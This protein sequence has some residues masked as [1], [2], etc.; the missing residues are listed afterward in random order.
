MSETLLSPGILTR[1]ND[2]S[3]VQPAPIEA[4]AAFIGP[5]VK[6]PVL[7]PT[8]V[9]SYNEYVRKFGDVVE[10]QG[11]IV[12]YFTSIGVRQY[13]SQGGT[14]AL[15][16]RVV[17]GSFTSAKASGS[18]IPFTLE[19]LGKGAIYN[20]SGSEGT[21]GSLANGTT[22]N[23]R[24]EVTAV[25]NNT[26][27]FTI[28]LR[29]GDDTIKNK[30]ILESFT[31][32]LDPTSDIFIEK[33]IGTQTRIE[34]TDTGTGDVYFETVGE[35]INR[36][37]FIRVSEIDPITNYTPADSGSLPLA[38]SG[39]FEEALGTISTTAGFFTAASGSTPQGIPAASY[40]KA[41]SLLESKD[42]YQFNIVAAPGINYESNTAAVAGLISLAE[43]RQDCVAVV[44]TVGYGRLVQDVKQSA[45]TID[46]SYAATYWPW[47]QMRSVTGKNVWV[48]ASTVI[49]SIFVLT[50]RISAPWFAPAGLIRGG[51]PGVIQT[52]RKLTVANRDT[53]YS[54]N[55]NP[56][57]T[58]PGQGI[59]VLGQKTL[60]SRA[61][62]LDRVNVRRL[63]IEV[64][65]FISDVSAGLLFEQNTIATRNRFLAS[66]NPYLE[67]VTQ[68][69]GLFAYRVV[70]DETNN[71]ADVIDRN[72]LIG[73]IYIQPTKTA[74][75]I[76]LDF[77]VEPTGATF[78]A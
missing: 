41:Y 31:V 6:G 45:D 22:D 10:Y 4:G 27:T 53:L 44:D 68:R 60:Q 29:R 24:W 7:E 72:Q 77:T 43:S 5:A 21:D 17:S 1:E 67:S 46:S 47:L 55:V 61:S 19:T 33:V 35:F 70:M 2:L 18:T 11:S 26:G 40:E 48:P 25:N 37:N 52:E 12:E 71:T 54:S 59:V 78:G 69:Q 32:S 30:I 75:F 3:F 20:S 58:L 34:R 62:A 28:L 74:E 9:T 49:P 50:D 51:L 66:V 57:A 39:S 23:F 64:K 73:Q 63:L 8:I 56:I 76:I 13:F 38:Q 42:E 65:K 36:S 16:S 14:T 15:I